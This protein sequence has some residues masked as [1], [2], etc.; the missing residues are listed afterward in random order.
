MADHRPPAPMDS[1]WPDPAQLEA[2]DQAWDRIEESLSVLVELTG[3]SNAA[4]RDLLAHISSTLLDPVEEIQWRT[5]SLERR[6]GR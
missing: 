4:L 3:C 6:H 1:H 2:A 5:R